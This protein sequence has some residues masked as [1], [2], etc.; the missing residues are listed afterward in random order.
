MRKYNVALDGH[1]VFNTD[2]I[3]RAVR[4]CRNLM[5]CGV[6]RE[7]IAVWNEDGHIID[8]QF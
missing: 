3:L 5:A 8:L 1:I 6:E 7:A 2:D 4:E